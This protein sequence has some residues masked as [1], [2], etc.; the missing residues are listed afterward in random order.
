MQRSVEKAV[1]VYSRLADVQRAF[2]RRHRKALASLT[3]VQWTPQEVHHGDAS[4]GEFGSIDEDVFVVGF[5]PRFSQGDGV[6]V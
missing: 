1:R 4:Q 3:Q 6:E 5:F 2:G